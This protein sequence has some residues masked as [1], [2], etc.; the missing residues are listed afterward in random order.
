MGHLA[1]QTELLTALET[2]ARPAI[3][4]LDRELVGI[5]I[6]ALVEQG[7]DDLILDSLEDALVKMKA[8]T[9]VLRALLT[10]EGGAAPECA[11]SS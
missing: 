4:L 1:S 3:E 11:G 7:V 5:S 6:Q 8:A 10:P 2:M 9:R